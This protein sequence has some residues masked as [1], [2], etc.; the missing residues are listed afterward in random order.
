MRNYLYVLLLGIAMSGCKTEKE[1][2]A[3][4]EITHPY[5]KLVWSDEFDYTGLP[6]SD[7]WDYS[8]G[9]GCPNICGWGNNELQY[10]TK[11]SLKNARVEDGK[12]IIELLPEQIESSEFSSAK[13]I[14]KGKQE[15]LYGRF[16]IR[17]KVP[18]SLG[19]WAA[20]WMMPSESS[21]GAWPKSGE[22]DIMEH[23]GYD[24]D[25]VVSTAH[26]ETN[27]HRIG[28]QKTS[29]V[30]LPDCDE[31][32]YTYSLEWEPNEYRTYIDDQLFFTYK[33]DG[34]GSGVWPFDQPFYLILNLAFGGDWGGSRG[35]DPS[36]LPR[37]MEIDYVRVYQ[38]SQPSDLQASMN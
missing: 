33:N 31:N 37:K 38:K 30:A 22:I 17:A 16:E 27:N 29:R 36:L 21:Y 18:A 14:T 34:S 2:K 32:F 19:T 15:W 13:L 1:H 8:I 28:N 25:T 23:V 24:P 11:D 9:N 10:Y 20:V 3:E 4:E 6:D 35:V 5:G 26:T 7:R 12:L